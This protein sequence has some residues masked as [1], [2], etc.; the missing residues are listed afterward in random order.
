MTW[1]DVLAPAMQSAKMQE[2]KTFLQTERLTKNIYPAGTDVWRAFDLCPL[3]I[4]KVVILGQ[5]P[6]CTPDTADGLAFSTRQDKL[7]P[8]LE[9]IFKEIYKDMNIQYYHNQSFEDYFPTGNLE[10][11][12]RNGFLLINTILTVEDGKPLSHKDLG[13]NDIITKVFDGLNQ[14]EEQ[15]IF[16]LWGNE[17]KKYEDL[18]DPKSKHVVFKASHPASEL[19]EGGKGGFYGC[20]HFS[21][22]RDVIA[23]MDGK[24]SLRSVNLDSCFDKEKAKE[25]VKKYYP[26]ESDKICKYIDE[27]LIIH[28]PV[29]KETYW[30]EIRKFE[31]FISTKIETDE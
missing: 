17:A 3:D 16:L 4:T 21:I 19:H 22:V 15:V 11:W 7:P 23:T 9:V 26:I 29:N 18:I 5:D 27:D 1:K 2:I 8:S 6:Y 28:C 30:N 24:N 12:A 10:S 31:N 13:W 25:I 14:K 20:R